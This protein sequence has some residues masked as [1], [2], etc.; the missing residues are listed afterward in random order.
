MKKIT[1]TF[2]NGPDPECTPRVLDELAKRDIKSTFFVC[3]GGSPDTH[4]AMEACSPRGLAILNRARNEGHWIGNHSLTHTV[5]LGTDVGL[6]LPEREIGLAQEML[7]DLAE[8]HRLFRPFMSGGLFGPRC[9]SPAAVDYLCKN[10]YTAVMFDCLPR[11]WQNPKTWPEV[12]LEIIEP[13]DWACVLVH[14]LARTGAMAQLPRFLD[15]C[16]ENGFEFTQEFSPSILPI[17][18][19]ELVPGALDGLI[20]GDKP[21][22]TLVETRP[23]F[24]NRR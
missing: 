16:L 14:D 12:A 8:E 24:L 2:D 15:Q 17:V 3:A 21:E 22:P 19:G 20:C 1:L 13:L 9:F 4:A 5:E 6:E 7:G 11:D 18:R 10:K 23:Y